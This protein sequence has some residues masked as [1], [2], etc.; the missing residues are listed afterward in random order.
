MKNW[1]GYLEWQPTQVAYPTNEAEIQALVFQALE[2]K[3]KIRCIGTGHSFTPVVK[4]N[5]I[6]ISLDKYQGLVSV[7]KEKCQATV[8]AGTKLSLLGELLF[9]QGMGMENLGDIDVQSIA[10][11]ISTGTHGTGS[12]LGTI[13]TQV[14]GL[15]WVNGKGEIVTCSTTEQPELLKAAQVSLGMMGVFTEVT[16]QCVPAYKLKLQNRKETLQEVLCSLKERN[17]THRNFEFFWFPYTDTV[18]TKSTNIT[19]DAPEKMT[20][21]NYFSEYILE[22]YAFL[23]FCEI[24]HKIP[25]LN[26]RLSKIG[27]A[28]ISDS[29]KNHHSHK[30]YATERLVRFNEM[31]YNVP[32]EAHV[33][34]LGE[35][36]KVVNSKKFDIF[37]PIENRTVQADD[38]FLSP[39]YQRDA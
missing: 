16:L 11:T 29:S 23:A 3:Q 25:S 14:I 7:D 6:L 38:I 32:V 39:A 22:N 36:T 30:I 10:G 18:W 28:T 1:S 34:V 15:K 13:S 19:A 4:T 20:W 35:I 27:A 37:F 33:E 26:A 31:E 2:N 12:R 21:T 8:K 17:A 5:D 9:E 24:T